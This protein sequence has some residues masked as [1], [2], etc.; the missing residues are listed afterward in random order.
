MKQVIKDYPNYE[1]TTSGKV[2]SSYKKGIELVPRVNKGGYLYVNLYNENGRKTKKIHRLVA[3]TFIP[4][5][6]NLPQ[7][8]HKD[9]NKLNNHIENLEWCNQSYNTQHAVKHS[10]IDFKSERHRLASR[11]NGALYGGRGGR[12]VYAMNVKTGFIKIFNS[13]VE[14]TKNLCTTESILRS[15]IS[16]GKCINGYQVWYAD[17]LASTMD[18]EPC[19]GL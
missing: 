3:E 8:N 17:T 1:I 9:G 7:V 13:V 4:N 2:I 16:K 12:K 11:N 14:A 15:I 6:Q 10:L 19:K 18:G 5:P